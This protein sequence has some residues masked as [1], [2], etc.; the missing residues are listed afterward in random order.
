MRSRSIRDIRRAE[1]SLA[2]FEAVIRYGLR[3][4]TIDKVGEIA[5][6]SKGVVLHYFKDKSALLEAAF[7]RS[8]SLLSKSVVELYRHAETPHERFWSIIVA[9][10]FETIFNRRVCQAWASLISEVPHNTQCQRI[11]NACNERIRSNLQHELKNFLPPDDAM[12]AARQLGVLIDGIWVR[13]VVRPDQI[14][15]DAAISEIEFAVSKLLPFDDADADRHREAL[16]KVKT[17]ATI[18]LGSRAFRESA[19]QA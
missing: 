4:T 5:G 19:Q 15:S 16:D 13:A 11:Q 10:F 8:N 18:V 6:V 1:L 14:S 17:V 9:N 12:R 2:A 7:R 3:G